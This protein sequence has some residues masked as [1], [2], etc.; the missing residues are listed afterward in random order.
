MRAEQYNQ[1]ALA[2]AK[3]APLICEVFGNDT[4]TGE[5]LPVRCPYPNGE[6]TY[7]AQSWEADASGLRCS[8]NNLPTCATSGTPILLGI[9]SSIV[10]ILKA[11][12]DIQS[13]LPAAERIADCQYAAETFRKLGGHRDILDNLHVAWVALTVAGMSPCHWCGKL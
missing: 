12:S 2:G 4:T 7:T 1:T 6:T 3:P 5:W 13:A 11:A 10:S 9:Y 8:G